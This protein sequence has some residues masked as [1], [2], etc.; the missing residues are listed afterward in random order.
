M[1]PRERSRPLTMPSVM[2]VGFFGDFWNLLWK[3]LLTH[4][5]SLLEAE[6]WL[7]RDS[8]ILEFCLYSF[9]PQLI[10]LCFK[11]PDRAGTRQIILLHA[12]GSRAG[13]TSMLQTALE[14]WCRLASDEARRLDRKERHPRQWR[15][16]SA[17]PT[18]G[19]PLGPWGSAAPSILLLLSISTKG[20][21][22]ENCN[23]ETFVPKT[24]L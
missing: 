6:D 4:T 2:G 5:V 9:G 3:K 17:L 11:T 19:A 21:P 18:P 12:T 10:F 1:Q 24:A 13:K 15:R 7:K 16:N 20:I 14:K 23:P 22:C 8:G